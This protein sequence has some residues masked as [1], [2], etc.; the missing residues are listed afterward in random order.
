MLVRNWVLNQLSHRLFEE[1]LPGINDESTSA[2]ERTD[3]LVAH[4]AIV[5]LLERIPAGDPTLAL[6]FIGF[7]EYAFCANNPVNSVDLYGLKEGA[8]G[9][10]ARSE[11]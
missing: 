2:S 8:G 6:R 5:L 3:L 7:H 1:I 4:H 10:L 9:G 11:N